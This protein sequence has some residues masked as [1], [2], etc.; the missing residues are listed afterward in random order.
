MELDTLYMLVSEAIERAESLDDIGAPGAQAAHLDV[1][2]VEDEIASL[3]SAAETEGRIA[4]RGVVRHA[5]A[6]GAYERAT[7]AVSR[8]SAE[9][10]ADDSLRLELAE[11]IQDAYVTMEQRYPRSTARFGTAEIH[12]VVAAFYLQGMPFPVAS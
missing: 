4:R 5:L 2:M 9:A 10:A 11:L 1:S 3:T 6:A 7:N 12:R 8:F